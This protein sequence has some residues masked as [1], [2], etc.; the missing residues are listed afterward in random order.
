MDIKIIADYLFEAMNSKDFS[1]VQ[2]YFSEDIEF[3]F[4]GAGIVKGQKRVII[5]LKALSRKYPDL[6]F[7][8][9]EYITES[10]KTVAIWTN[11]GTQT[12][13]EEYSNSGVTLLRIENEKIV[14]LSDYFKDTSFTEK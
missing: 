11:K 5:F 13:G 1:K 10:N 4:P 7:T 8:V 3:D 12:T 2:E 9:S 14:F 6:T